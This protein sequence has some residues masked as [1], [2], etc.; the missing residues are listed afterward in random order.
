LMIS[1][2]LRDPSRLR[3]KTISYKIE[4]QKNALPPDKK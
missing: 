2:R 4:Q 3:G 1:S